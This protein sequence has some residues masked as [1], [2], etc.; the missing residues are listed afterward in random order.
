MKIVTDLCCLSIKSYQYR[1]KRVMHVIIE[2]TTLSRQTIKIGP[3]LALSEAL[4]RV[5]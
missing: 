2:Q 4:L 5:H 1:S 3:V